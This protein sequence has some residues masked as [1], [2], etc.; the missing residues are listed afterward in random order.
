MGCRVGMSSNPQERIDYW[1]E[2]EGHT[3]GKILAS[4]LTYDEA[5]H[6]EKEEAVNKGCVSSPG[7]PRIRGRV[8]SV[9]YV[10]GGN[11]S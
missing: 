6:R 11:T 8:W 7:G 4:E 3:Y 2:E 1:K 10:S 9:Y 5:Q